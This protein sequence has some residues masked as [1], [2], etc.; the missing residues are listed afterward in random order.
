MSALGEPSPNVGEGAVTTIDCPSWCRSGPHVPDD[1]H[2]TTVTTVGDVSI[3]VDQYINLDGTSTGEPVL[4]RLHGIDAYTEF[5]AQRC[6]GL[7][8]ALLETARFVEGAQAS[9]RGRT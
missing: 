8:A 9:H 2:A 6:R 3:K 5:D 7:A 1:L 4:V